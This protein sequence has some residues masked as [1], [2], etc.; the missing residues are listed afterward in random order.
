[1]VISRGGENVIGFARVVSFTLLV[2]GTGCHAALGAVAGWE[3]R[4][5]KL[6]NGAGPT[7]SEPIPTPASVTSP[8]LAPKEP[9]QNV[10]AKR[11]GGAP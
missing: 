9:A 3:D 5:H 2:S 4:P 6:K 8:D 11:E 7:S 1:M 10:L